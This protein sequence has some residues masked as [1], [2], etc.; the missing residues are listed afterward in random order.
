MKGQSSDANF[1]LNPFCTNAPRVGLLSGRSSV[2]SP[3]CC[4]TLSTLDHRPS[5][6]SDI[7]RNFS[8]SAEMRLF[9]FQL[10]FTINQF[11]ADVIFQRRTFVY[12]AIDMSS[13]KFVIF[14]TSNCISNHLS[15]QQ[16]H[17][18]CAVLQR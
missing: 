4:A 12:S 9:S 6:R 16:I 13:H 1:E 18:L 5:A 2:C 17:E 11:V 15:E 14:H 7:R 8:T 10:R 3:H